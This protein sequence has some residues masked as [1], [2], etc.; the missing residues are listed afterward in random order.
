MDA[1]VVIAHPGANSL[2]ARLAEVTTKTL[3]NLGYAVTTSDLY[4]MDWK[5]AVTP[6]DFGVP[7][8]RTSRSATSQR[9]RTSVAR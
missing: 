4:A 5:A 8:A 1:L 3:P 9:R 6:Q 7:S 2:N